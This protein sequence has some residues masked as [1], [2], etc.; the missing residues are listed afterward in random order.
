MTEKIIE[1]LKALDTT[2]DN[3]WT[4]DGL[5]RLETVKF[6]AADQSITREQVNQA[7]PGF[8]RS[9]PV[10]PVGDNDGSTDGRSETGTGETADETTNTGT[11]DEPGATRT[12]GQTTDVAATGI[13]TVPGTGDSGAAGG[14]E[15]TLSGGNDT[16]HEDGA[17]G[18]PN[19]TVPGDEASE[20]QQPEVEVGDEDDADEES[21]LEAELEEAEAEV[22][23]L[24]QQRDRLLAHLQQ[25]SEARDLLQARV[26]KQKAATP[27]AVV[28]Q[29]Y[30]KSQDKIRASRLAARQALSESGLTLKDLS[31]A[32]GSAPIDQAMARKTGRGRPTRV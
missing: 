18:A 30:F 21:A 6:N 1:A 28:I 16:P 8:T 15:S 23:Y 31:K 19:E 2:N 10:T 4:T 22:Q 17:A 3:H 7:A 32:I 14:Q 24:I 25:V 29:D 27:Q 5:P 9:N 11:A 12:V 26:D 20:A 13:V